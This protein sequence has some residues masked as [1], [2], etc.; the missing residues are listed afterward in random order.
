MHLHYLYVYLHYF[1]K[2][3]T[4]RISIG[5]FMQISFLNYT[6]MQMICF[7][8]KSSVLLKKNSYKDKQKKSRTVMQ[9]LI[10][11]GRL[12]GLEPTSAG[13]TIQ[14]VDQLHHSRHKARDIIHL[15]AFQCKHKLMVSD[16]CCVVTPDLFRQLHIFIFCIPFLRCHYFII[17]PKEMIPDLRCMEP[18][19]QI[20]I[21]PF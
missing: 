15:R 19:I 13:A 12:V 4:V 6:D 21:S 14:C 16:Q 9:L 3:D 2:E 20:K 11:Y 7:S 8:E 18:G 5:V 1:T 17:D 10:S